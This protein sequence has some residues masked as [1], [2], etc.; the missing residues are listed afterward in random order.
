MKFLFANELSEMSPGYLCISM[1]RFISEVIMRLIEQ[2]SS[3]NY[4][5]SVKVPICF[6]S[7]TSGQLDLFDEAL[8]EL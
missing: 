5:L 1:F 7:F 4:S 2:N 6:F 8:V 3:N